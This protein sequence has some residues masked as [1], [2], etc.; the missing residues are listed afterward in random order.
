[1][2]PKEGE[3]E[4]EREKKNCVQMLY[5]VLFRMNEFTTPT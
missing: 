2:L 5:E 1:M 3:R 4:R